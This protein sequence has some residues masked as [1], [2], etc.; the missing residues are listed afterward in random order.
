M[1][2]DNIAKA[3][4]STKKAQKANSIKIPDR[5]VSTKPI[6]Q[7]PEPINKLYKFHLKIAHRAF[8]FI[9]DEEVGFYTNVTKAGYMVPV[10]IKST[11]KFT[12]SEFTDALLN[13]C[14]DAF[15]GGRGT[16]QYYA[17]FRNRFSLYDDYPEYRNYGTS[18]F[19]TEWKVY[20]G[21]LELDDQDGNNLVPLPKWPNLNIE[22][23]SITV[24]E[25]ISNASFIT[26]EPK[27]KAR[28]KARAIQDDL[29]IHLTLVFKYLI[30]PPPPSPELGTI[31]T[32][33]RSPSPHSSVLPPPIDETASQ[34]EQL[35]VSTPVHSHKRGISEATPRL[36]REQEEA[37]ESRSRAGRL[38]KP[39][40]KATAA[41]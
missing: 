26:E 12:Y 21:H 38:R 3:K 36:E 33:E 19:Q 25:L 22:E 39:S 4:A 18:V 23:R 29:T 1:R 30:E 20:T 17:I 34:V 41:E 2:A 28:A 7:E 40:A 35:S 11:M 32:I 9:D 14:K 5:P 6:I 24:E 37:V 13:E 10:P 27:A 31:A 8:Q 16:E 15:P